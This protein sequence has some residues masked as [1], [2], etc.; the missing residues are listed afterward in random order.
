MTDVQLLNGRWG[1]YLAIGKDNY[2]LPK[3]T[4]AAKLTLQSA[5][6]LQLTQPMQVK[7]I[8]S[9][10]K[11]HLLKLQQLKKQVLKRLRQKKTVK[12]TEKII[13]VF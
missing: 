10:K 6:K 1:P 8:S 3:G 9:E 5:W 12:K 2:K 13:S 11:K 4:D 7:P